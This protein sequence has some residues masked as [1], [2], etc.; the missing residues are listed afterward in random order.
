MSKAPV[1]VEETNN[2]PAHLAS[3]KTTRVGNIDASDLIIPRIKLLQGISPETQTFDAARA[4]QFWHSMLDMPL[5]TSLPFI[6]I[7]IRK[8]YV[9]WAPRG[10]ERGILARAPDAVNW[11]VKDEFE[12]KFK[13]IPEKIKWST[14]AGTV[15]ASGLDQF[16]TK[17]PNDPNSAPAA[18]LQYN[19]LGYFPTLAADGAALAILLNSRSSVQP[20]KKLLSAID[21]K[22]VDHYYQQYKVEVV[23]ETK[24]GDDFFNYQY[25]SDG[26]VQDE[27]L[28]AVTRSLFD[29][30]GALNFRTNDES[31]DNE[32][33]GGS[34]PANSKF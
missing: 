4:G 1:K 8:S 29:R 20:A 5:G 9:L 13:E 23:K 22:P 26:Y 12:V 6:P 33:S 10:D 14:K 16:G 34:A 18:T 7:V 2:L 30:Y 19:I 32:A 27:A 24:N 15:Q 17:N 28:A 31:E 21:L 3:G 11:D 25:V